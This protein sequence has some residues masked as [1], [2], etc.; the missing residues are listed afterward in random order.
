MDTRHNSAKTRDGHHYLSLQNTE[1]IIETSG[2]RI[3]VANMTVL[4]SGGLEW[5]S[6]M[7]SGGYNIF[8]THMG[9]ET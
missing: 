3:A 5:V 6:R 8:F 4:V 1:N 7:L 2:I 9:H